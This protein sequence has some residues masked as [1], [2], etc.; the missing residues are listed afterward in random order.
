[1]DPEYPNIVKNCED[2]RMKIFKLLLMKANVSLIYSYFHDNNDKKQNI[3]FL[4]YKAFSGY[5]IAR[6]FALLGQYN[7]CYHWFSRAKLEYNLPPLEYMIH[8]KDFTPVVF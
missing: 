3:W 4:G 5:Y 2:D 6:I 1:L 7:E 8:N